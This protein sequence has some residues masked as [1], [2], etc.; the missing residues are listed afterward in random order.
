MIMIIDYMSVIIDSFYLNFEFSSPLIGMETIEARIMSLQSFKRDIVSEIVSDRNAHSFVHS[1]S[2]LLN[3][4]TTEGSNA[5]PHVGAT[6]SSF[7]GA[8]W[9]SVKSHAIGEDAS[10][11]HVGRYQTSRSQTYQRWMEEVTIL[12]DHSYL[13]FIF[14]FDI[15]FI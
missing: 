3:D 11:G 9:S 7:E 2:T 8:L 4:S 1:T 5:I 10:G 14:F 13:F 6:S 15:S 12:Y